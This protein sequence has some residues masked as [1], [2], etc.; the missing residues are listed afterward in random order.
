M[1]RHC[2][3]CAARGT[4]AFDVTH[5]LAHP[6]RY[7]RKGTFYI[8]KRPTITSRQ[9]NILSASFVQSFERCH[10]LH[11][12]GYRPGRVTGSDRS[13]APAVSA[14]MCGSRCTARRKIVSTSCRTKAASRSILR[15][16]GGHVAAAI[17][18]GSQGARRMRTAARNPRG[19]NDASPPPGRTKAAL[20]PSSQGSFWCNLSSAFDCR[21]GEN[22][23]CIHWSLLQITTTDFTLIDLG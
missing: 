10:L 21:S 7:G 12:R 5:C 4:W 13:M 14:R 17:L 9:E 2:W 18:R 1:T 22:C 6:R 8:Y 19:A 15:L 3:R 23:Q 20:M 11:A 16:R